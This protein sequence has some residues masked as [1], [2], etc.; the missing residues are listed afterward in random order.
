MDDRNF[1]RVINRKN[2]HSVK[3]D[4]TLRFHGENHLFPMWV[5]DMDFKSPQKVIEAL[6]TRAEHGIFGYTSIP[7]STYDAIVH[8]LQKRHNWSIKHEWMSVSTGIVPSIAMAI[9]A[10]SKPGDK[11]ILQSPV[12]YPF[13]DMIEKNNRVIVNN[14]LIFKDGAYTIDFDKLEKMIDSNVKL[15]LL[16]N[17]HNPGGRVWTKEELT[18][19]GNICMKHNIL[20]ISDEIHS[21][22]IFSGHT[23][24]PFA[25]ICDKFAQHSITC[26]APSKTFNLAGLQTAA[27]IIPNRSIRNTYN[28]Y[29]HSQGFFTLN[30]FG[31]VAMEAAYLHG[32]KWLDHLLSYVEENVDLVIAYFNKHIPKLN[33]MKP[34]GTYLVWVD[35]RDL[36]ITDAEIKRLLL[37]KGKLALEYGPTFGPGGEGFIRI[38]VACPKE[39]LHEGLQRLEKAFQ[40]F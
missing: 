2:T 8:W 22:L 28:D 4:E 19:L 29:Q 27:L 38:N 5:A 25:S 7:Q 34:Q 14:S 3:W 15:L 37:E 10:F 32:E 11:V 26:I 36:K 40:A 30:T 39:T 31:I 17:P 6:V 16:C 18:K 21:D 23:H 12:Y 24:I 13:F 35:C 9:Q 1:D 20:V 33:V